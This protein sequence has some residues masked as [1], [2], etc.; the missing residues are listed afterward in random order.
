MGRG[1]SGRI[2]PK[3]GGRCGEQQRKK[4]EVLNGEFHGD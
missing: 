4:E 3:L 2:K 1:D